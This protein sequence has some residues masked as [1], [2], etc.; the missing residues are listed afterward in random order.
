MPRLRHDPDM[1][2]AHGGYIVIEDE[3]VARLQ[4]EARRAEEAEWRAK[5]GPVKVYFVDP[6]TLK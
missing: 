5:C 3:N 2:L 1:D 4:R 6:E